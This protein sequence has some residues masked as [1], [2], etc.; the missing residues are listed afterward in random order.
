MTR[1]AIDI[2]VSSR[3]RILGL[4]KAELA[5]RCGLKNDRSA[6]GRI[7][8]LHCE[9]PHSNLRQILPEAL[10]VE[11]S[12]VEAAYCLT[13]RQLQHIQA[14]EVRLFET[15]ANTAPRGWIR[16]VRT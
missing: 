1:L 4:S 13:S 3:C 7:D 12:C 6:I 8:C 2:L 9:P 5:I 14:A 16:Q 10:Q 11:P 15:T